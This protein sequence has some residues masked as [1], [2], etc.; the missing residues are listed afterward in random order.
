MPPYLLQALSV[1]DVQPNRHNDLNPNKISKNKWVQ[2]FRT[3]YCSS[4]FPL[5]DFLPATIINPVVIHEW[6]SEARFG[7]KFGNV[8]D[9]SLESNL[10]RHDIS[11]RGK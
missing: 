11:I 2:E 7:G 9:V 5:P 3:F 6:A 8:V 10:G 1:S 4:L